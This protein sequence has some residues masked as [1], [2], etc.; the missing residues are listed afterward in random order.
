MNSLRQLISRTHTGGEFFS[1][2][3]ISG[4]HVSS[5]EMIRNE[6]ADV[7]AIDCVMLALLERYQ[8]DVMQGIRVLGTTYDAPAPPF[9]VRADT[10]DDEVE[11]IRLALMD[12][13][14][15]PATEQCRQDMLLEGLIPA[16][17]D[18]YWVI[19][20]FENFATKRNF[21]MVSQAIEKGW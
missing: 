4:S 7:A 1:E 16:T 15:D 18:D 3:K 19:N 13:F 11:K 20:A 8:P 17:I 10:P 9:V 5:L 2:L 12:T 14:D 6:Q 21:K